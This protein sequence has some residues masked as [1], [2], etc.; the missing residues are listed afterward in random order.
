MSHQATPPQ[1]EI[2]RD[3]ISLIDKGGDRNWVYSKK[4][5]GPLYTGRTWFSIALMVLL[6][7]GPFIKLKGHPLL[8]LNVLERKFI[9]FGIP[10]WPQDLPLFALLMITF[11]VFIILFTVIFGR[12]F[13]GWACPQTIF[14]EMLFRKIEYLIEGDYK[15]QKKLDDQDWNSEKIVKKTV[16]H[17]IFYLLAVVIANTFLSY[18]IGVDEVWKLIEEGPMAH[19]GKF[20]ALII[21]STVFYAVFAKFREIIC[22]VVC[23]YG[24]LQGLMLDRN[25]I[26]V[27]Y[28]FVRGEPRGLHKKNLETKL[29]DCVDCNRC[30]HVCPTGIDI[31]NG[32]QLE[33]INCTACIDECND[34]MVK[35]KKPKGLIRY[36]SQ[37]EVVSGIVKRV[38]FRSIAYTTILLILVS[39]LTYLL[40]TRKEIDSTVL[41]TPG[42]LHQVQSEGMISNMYNFEVVNKTFYNKHIEIKVTK[43]ITAKLK[44]V[45][46]NSPQFELN[47]DEL[48]KGSFFII[49]PQSDIKSNNI[50]TEIEIYSN[51]KL[52][53]TIE[54]NFV[55]PVKL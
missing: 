27:A 5:K 30:V 47:E 31:R 9:I 11:V 22:L 36:A 3:S 39:T 43:P 29:G 32:T 24:R 38:T 34:V 10:F 51:N 6:F 33:C 53:R 8:L 26:V 4:P 25:S 37:A 16:K 15:A 28:D 50:N 21:F 17:I 52:I 49:I 48:A 40:S 20:F 44:M 46:R 19:L 45:D 1:G 54:T 12:M 35:M 2:Y 13:C 55:G 23:P 7:L 42:M 14:M 41:R 18:L